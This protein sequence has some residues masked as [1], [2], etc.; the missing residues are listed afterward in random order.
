MSKDYCIRGMA[1]NDQVRFFIAT[2]KNMVEEARKRFELTPLSSAALGRVLTA[3]SMMGMNLK[4]NDNITISFKG[5]GPLGDV[6]ARSNSQGEVKGYCSNPDID[7]P[8]KGNGKID[9]SSGIGFGTL[10][11]SKD[12]GLKE[13]YVGT[14][15]IVSGEIGE[16]LTEYFYSSEQTLSAV[17][18]GVLVDV[19]YTIKSAGGFI[20]QLMPEADESIGVFLEERLKLISSISSY[21]IENKPDDL[22]KLLF[23]DDYKVLET[24]E[25]SFK[26]QCSKEN[27]ASALVTLGNDE[28]EKLALDD[29]IE[30]VCQFCNEK[31]IFEKKEIKDLIKNMK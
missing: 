23:S 2:S 9:V 11:I 30:V 3:T 27:F 14:V 26:C 19:D 1:L 10:Y 20:I 13:P 7:L 4:G 24:K 12:M 15:P 6:V 16:D 31:Y 28:L 21:F 22:A 29:E 5:N 25:I 18:L 17:G 8:L